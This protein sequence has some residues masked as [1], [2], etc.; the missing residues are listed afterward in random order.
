[1]IPA[2]PVAAEG[3]AAEVA[4]LIERLHDTGQRL[5]EL[6]RGEVDAVADRD[7]QTFVLRRA[8][9][10]LRRNET[11]KQAA[12]LDALPTHIALLDPDGCIVSVNAAWQ[13]FAD[14]NGLHSPGHAVGINYLAICDEARG[15]DSLEAHQVA[16]GI[17]TVLSGQAKSFS[18]EYPCHSPAEQRWFLMTVTPL[19]RDCSI[20]V[21]VMHL[22]ITQRK[23]MES[24]LQRSQSE[25]R[26]LFDLMPAMIWFK[27]THNGILRVNKLVAQ[28]LGKPVAEI[29]GR[30]AVEIYPQDAAKFYADDLE[31]IRSGCAKLEIIETRKRADGTRRWFQTDKVP[32]FDANDNVVGI[33][34]MARDIT[35]RKQNEEDLQ[36]SESRYRQLFDAS[37][38]PMWVYDL[39]T[40]AFL[41]IN[42]AAVAHYG[43]SRE[44]FLAMTIADIRPES[45]V[46]ALQESLHG[47]P[48]GIQSS[49]VWQHRKAGGEIIDV[50]VTSHFL[51]FS[52]RPARL[53]LAN[54]VT[55]RKHSERAL[56]RTLARLNEAQRIGQIG[57]WEWDLATR[58]MT[59]SPQV[60][61][62]VGRDPRL[63]PPQDYAEQATF[64]DAPS[65][66]LMA[67]KVALAIES[68]DA[69][70]YDLR[71]RRPDG[72][73]IHAHAVAVP[74]KDERGTV[75]RLHGTVQDISTRERLSAAVGE[76]ERRYRSLFENMLEGY[77]CCR[78]VF[79]GDEL[80]DFV[81]V[82]VNSAFEKLTGLQEVIGKKV[83][84]VIPGIQQAQPELFTTYG[85][86]A[87]SGMPRKFELYIEALGIWLSI[88]AYSDDR[89][90]FVAIFEDISAR[91]L[92]LLAVQKSEAEQR[93]IAQQLEVERS[94][95]MTAQRIGK[96]GSWEMDLV[97]SA[98]I[99]SAETYRIFEAD[100][101]TTAASRQNFLEFVHPEDRAAVADAFEKSLAR[102]TTSTIQHRLL[103]PSAHVKYVE[104]RW[105]VIRD[106]QE[107]AIRLVGTC[108]DISESKWADELVRKSSGDG[109]WKQQRKI[110]VEIGILAA[111]TAFIYLLGARFDWF[112][113]I[114][115][116]VL[117][118]GQLD[119]A[120]VAALFLS[121][122]LV[123]F[124]FRRMRESQAAL[125]G[126]RGVQGALRLLHDDL[127]RQVEQRT[128]DLANANQALGGEIV[129][130]TEQE[131]KITRL[132]R[133]R[134]V[135]GG[136]S[137]AMLRLHDRDELLGEA[138]R[139]AAT[140][141]VFPMA[142]VTVLD[143]LRQKL[144]IVSWHGSDPQSGDLISKL[145]ARKTWLQDDRPSHL[146]MQSAR[147]VIVNDLA[148]EPKM[149][150]ISEDL[151]SRGYQSIAAFPLLVEA[152]VVAVLMLL[153]SERDFF[154][155]EEIAL[156]QWLTADLS[157]ALE[158]IQKSQQLNYLAYYDSVTGLP[159][160]Q[161]FR[162]RLDQFINAAEQD[163][164]KVCVLV[165]DLE[166]FTQINNTFGRAVGDQVLRQ[167]GAR[168]QEFLVEP[169][170]LGHIGADT[171]AVA[172]PM[173][174]EIVATKLRD[175]ML[176]ALRQP[177]DFE[178][179][180]VGIT[181]QAGIALYPTDGSDGASVFKNAELA[182]KLAKSSGER[183]VYHSSEMNDQV[184]RRFELERQLRIAV[185]AR[186]FVLHYQPKV[187]MISGEMIGAEALIRWQHPDKGLV[188]PAE[189]IALAE[190]TGLIV[191]IGS[192]V[193]QTVCAQQAAWTKAGIRTVPIA[194]NLSSVQFERG[195]VLQVVR[196][197]LAV[198]SIDGKL[199]DLELTESVVMNDS[200]SAAGTLHALR[201]LGVGLAL[202][203]FGTGYS[204]L[205]HLKR[206]PFDSVKIDISF[207]ADITHNAED[208]AIATAIIAMAHSLQ[209]KVVAEGVETLGQ[210]YYLRAHGC[211]QMQG[212]FF[213]PAVTGEALESD[214]RTGKRMTLPTAAPAEQR[215]LLLVDDEAG[216]RAALGRM[217]R[218]EGY[219]ILMAAS[220]A[221]ALELL[222]IN[223]V[224]VI[225]SD[226]RMPGMSGTEFLNIVKQ[227]YP[228]TIRMVLSGYTDLEV[229][230]ESVN[231]GAVFKFITKPWD[232]DLLRE[233][234][235]DAFRRYQ[236]ATT[237]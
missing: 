78:T 169:Y 41:A 230:T 25:L 31:V 187:D 183:F 29:E 212:Y 71:G 61:E 156:L 30:P 114:T 17:R 57:D 51:E 161:L 116:M 34:V 128:Q 171:F 208:A 94:L 106:E 150:A 91:M 144:N 155:A 99:W 176:E 157:F 105:Q 148:H 81:Y 42:D 107:N 174:D 159:N 225:V 45:A 112:E 60:F 113:T 180:A 75:F 136:I 131:R 133:I 6:T 59:W 122:T 143:P 55:E 108:Q 62:I 92:A 33:V 11:D 170:T 202:D 117:N 48:G 66:K 232:D 79:D 125:R 63:G 16:L 109:V 233:L 165:V 142:W 13:Q 129:K 104:E 200:A 102:Q 177:L 52:G 234:I 173:G 193:I 221:E 216:I 15:A 73:E 103:L 124:A 111:G 67:A 23:Q 178:G 86:V 7:G 3:V 69:Q 227:M 19:S 37:P 110:F 139:V 43:Y 153:A 141:G 167:V 1:M 205:A 222:A 20:G 96:I 228:G 203:D 93:H 215:T 123:V 204:S 98:G 164:G 135:I 68:G 220:G 172:S 39:Q 12:I 213:S 137:S 95:L 195:D 90:H 194:V 65:W 120:V 214:L 210:F 189:F 126:Q 152:R 44:Q 24:T 138:C 70:E 38:L 10:Q 231:R 175:C 217:L 191:P 162:D 207:V 197:A 186:Q 226:Q 27:D 22:N 83:S 97:S 218:R 118:E 127:D 160:L 87:L 47:V 88:T 147:P 219:R 9:E 206:F 64:Y 5:E 134:A 18:I 166:H 76:S 89:E 236:T 154:D 101:D 145:N 168:F 223:Q 36:A 209:L 196:N 74:E 8:Q 121:A 158:H 181:T 198:H 184:A 115:H 163:H 35:E 54:D 235:R 237:H 77:A 229:V 130:R 192:W 211:D 40:L 119:E 199:L 56:D 28:A 46:P 4:A 132:N 185:E 26:A 82:E 100:P 32:Y 2:K 14:A 190:E 49:G 149:A 224:Q 201:K 140:E 72:K 188:S 53:V 179:H 58:A 50:E 151:L 84:D 146:A 80:R 182:L 21:V 85:A